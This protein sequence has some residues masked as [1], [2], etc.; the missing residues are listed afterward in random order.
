MKTLYLLG[1]LMLSAHQDLAT[2]DI[3][4]IVKDSVVKIELSD[5]S[6]GSG[7]VVNRDG[8][9]VTNYHV[10]E[11]AALNAWTTITAVSSEGERA[12]CNI[13]DYDADLDLA[14]IQCD[15]T[16]VLPIPIVDP[17]T[18]RPGSKAIAIGAPYGQQDWVTEGII[19]KHTTP[20]LFTTTAINPG[21]SGGALVNGDANLIGITTAY[22]TQSNEMY[23]AVDA[24]SIMYILDL[25]GVEYESAE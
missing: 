3:F 22:Y 18:I 19:S 10:I 23:R 5:G 8:G 16:S 21:N 24:K 17:A 14:V 11:Q 25:N 15:L 13:I 6:T 12:Q 9:I 7:V 1:V 4:D 2:E 20:Y